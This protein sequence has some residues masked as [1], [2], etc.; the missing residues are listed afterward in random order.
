MREPLV[1][2][3]GQMRIKWVNESFYANFRLKPK[4]TED[5][6][7]YELD[8]GQWNIREVRKLFDKISQGRGRVTDYKFAHHFKGIGHRTLNMNASTVF[9]ESGD[10]QL[11]LPSI[12]D[13]TE[14]MREG[15]GQRMLLEHVPDNSVHLEKAK[16][17]LRSEIVDQL[18]QNNLMEQA[19]EETEKSEEER[20]AELLVAKE[21][22]KE[23]IIE[24]REMEDELL[25]T[26]RT[27]QMLSSKLLFAIENERRSIA[28]ELHES[29][30]ANLTAII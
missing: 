19:Q 25:E 26:G 15:E 20:A 29:I 1:I 10:P 11:V 21:L 23:E 18:D 22:I 13:I 6:L 17:A 7:I 14:K 2:L 12:Q 5:R 30:G 9:S 16:E 3:D 27:V 4:E 8:Q 28:M 24:H